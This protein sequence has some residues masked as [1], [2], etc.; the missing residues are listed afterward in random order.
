MQRRQFWKTV[1][2][3]LLIVVVFTLGTSLYIQTKAQTSTPEWIREWVAKYPPKR[4]VIV[5]GGS[6]SGHTCIFNLLTERTLEDQTAFEIVDRGDV[7]YVH[8]PALHAVH[9]WQEATEAME[10]AFWLPGP[11]QLVAVV[12]TNE[13]RVSAM[14]F[15]RI[16]TVLQSIHAPKDSLPQWG[17]VITRAPREM[18]PGPTCQEDQKRIFSVEEGGD[19]KTLQAWKEIINNSTALGDVGTMVA[20]VCIQCADAPETREKTAVQDK[21]QLQR[22]LQRLPTNTIDRS[23]V[24][25]ME[26]AP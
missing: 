4:N 14:K 8:T 21:E 17:L 11:T 3:I 23:R 1:T 24:R 10:K 2:L 22:F 7:R 5:F 20:H 26:V 6:A 25:R 19:G 13:G 9:G 15:T 18:E 16:V 12:G